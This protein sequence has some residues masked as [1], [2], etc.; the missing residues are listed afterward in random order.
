MDVAAL[1]LNV[2][3]SKVVQ[4]AN[5]LD[6]FAAS[7]DRAAASSAKVNFGNQSGS[8]AKLVASVQSMDSK[9]SAIVG[10]LERV[11]NAEKAV[12]TA[13]DNLVNSVDKA[14]SALAVADSHVIAYT[15]HLVALARAQRAA[16]TAPAMPRP[17]P[18]APPRPTSAAPSLPASTPS[19][20][21]PH[22]SASAISEVGT[23]SKL[24]A[25][26]V[27]NL[28]FQLND[29]FVGLASG[30]HPLTVFIQQGS[31]I[32]QIPVQAGKGFKQFGVEL[33]N[34]LGIIKRTGDASLD[35]A[36]SQAS[37]VAQTI[38]GYGKNAAAAAISAGA[39]IELAEAQAAVA[40]TATERT[41][42]ADRLA[43][44]QQAQIAADAEA[45]IAAGALASANQAVAA[46]AAEAAEAEA[47][48][49][50][51]LGL[52]IAAIV[53]V[54]ALF[55]A[56]L[57][58]LTSQANDDSGLKKY[59][60]A[61][62]YT[63]AEVEKLNA[64]TVT[65]GDTFKAVFQV[66]F[67]RIAAAFGLTTGDIK[68]A[69]SSVLD[70]LITATRATIAGIYSA[71][72]GLGYAVKRV[73]DNIKAGKAE[74][75]FTSLVEGHKAAYGDAQKFMDDVVK[76]ARTDAQKR[77]NDMAA[78]MHN[79]PHSGGA[80]AAAKKDPLTGILQSAQDE[81]DSE[82]TRAAAVGLSARAADEMTQ[83]TKILNQ[84]QKAG[85]PITDGLRA[86]VDSLSKAYADAKVAADTAAAIQGVVDSY[87]K[88]ADALSDTIDTIGLYGDALIRARTELAALT[89]ARNALPRGE[90]LS[91]D[92]S[93]RVLDAADQVARQQS[94]SDLLTR[95]EKVR[96]DAEDAQYA[97]DLERKG[98]GLTGA[99][100]EAYANSSERLN[101]AKKDGSTLSADEITQILSTADAYGKARY[102]ID[103]QKQSIAD[104]REVTKG[105]WT[106]F[107]DGARQGEN[108]FTAFA[109]A[110]TNALNKIIDKLLDK[111]LDSM[112]DKLFAGGGGAGGFLSSIF[113]GG[114]TVAAPDI[115]GVIA[116]TNA[117]RLP[118]FAKGGAFTNSIVSNPTLFRF[119]NGGAIGEMGEAGPE[120]IMPLKRGPNGA[121]G[122]QMHGG[123][124]KPNIR[125][126][127][128][129]NNYSL[130]GAIGADGI[131]SMVRQG[132]EATYS[133][134]KRDLQ[135]LLQQLDQDGALA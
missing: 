131:A 77:Q 96:K 22:A 48:A 113:G 98:L 132:G 52:A 17:V 102:A 41:A 40:A 125:M 64:V 85:I 12:V 1:A 24:A 80:S 67:E 78:A 119:A 69:W 130:A 120:A 71:F 97:M 9:L 114:S 61:M 89:S 7:S 124:G 30:Q 93:K 123:G 112:L 13:N 126:G 58:A 128:I 5:D 32:A 92:D 44:A 104:A 46:T 20:S 6:K 19:L 105:F 54:L 66:G 72:A 70:F 15:Q 100:A 82:K 53:A 103:Q 134:V 31:Q 95:T 62:G 2:D 87:D 26:E 47:V 37:A 118:G 34:T 21:S 57:A 101:A 56:G 39:E 99:A 116:Q 11:A 129:H 115:S 28:A 16:A 49:L 109:T 121:L 33:L 68:R 18:V 14:G 42:A 35:S 36:A 3:S 25:Y 94:S 79:A 91:G 108:V 4:A 55:T 60:T 51:P 127:D 8:I 110:V 117:I 86:K 107:I 90:S 59:T 43:A 38:A 63:K 133:Q 65:F 88:Q 84:I 10:T 83:R 75:P 45:A 23:Q 73:I 81:I 76:T 74:N 50:A 106:D 111:G 29:V 27:S 122:V 135:S